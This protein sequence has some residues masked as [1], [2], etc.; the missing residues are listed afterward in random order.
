MTGRE[1]LDYL[2]D[3]LGVDNMQISALSIARGTAKRRA[4]RA[5]AG[6]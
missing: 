6:E 4:R 5:C 3:E 2:N 1:L